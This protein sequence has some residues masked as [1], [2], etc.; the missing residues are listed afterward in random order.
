MNGRGAQSNPQNRFEPR[1][2]FVDPD[3]WQADADPE[4]MDPPAVHTR[5]FDDRTSRLITRNDSPDIPFDASINPYRGCEHGCAYC[6]A[7]PTHEYLNLSAGVDFES[8]IFVKRDAPEL[9]G[10]ELSGRAWRPRLIAMSGVTDPYQ[11]AERHFQITRACLEVLDSFRNPAGIVT[12]NH[13]VTRDIDILQRM[14]AWRGIVVYISITT[15][16]ETLRSRLEPRTS[17]IRMRLEAIRALAQ[18]G[19]PTGFLAAPVI[20]GLTDHQLPSIVAAAS[21]AG[22]AFGHYSILR[23]PYAV[24]AIFSEWVRR[25]YPESF[26]RISSR[27]HEVR[28]GQWN[29][30]GFGTRFSGTGPA[31]ENIRRVFRAFCHHHGVSMDSPACD[32]GQFRRIEPGQPEL[33]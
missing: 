1:E 24:K 9:L 17:S 21:E 5:F 4:P 7:R 15:M 13:L 22:A 26:E 28:G 29:D 20:P 18:A 32:T 30:P 2:I 23:L 16:D 8:R 14:S 10:R 31:A 3:A 25:F 6:Y 33:F 11:P 19:I 27:V 12:K